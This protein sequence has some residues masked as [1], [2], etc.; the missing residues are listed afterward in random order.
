VVEIEFESKKMFGHSLASIYDATATVGRY[1]V[2][3]GRMARRGRRRWALLLRSG[4]M[5]REPA[6]PSSWRYCDGL[7]SCATPHRRL[8]SRFRGVWVWPG[9][10]SIAALSLNLEIDA[11]CQK[12]TGSLVRLHR[13]RCKEFHPWA[14]SV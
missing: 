11:M 4:A 5:M 7:R 2:L 13:K 6:T 8:S 9:Y 14:R 10:P 3:W 1:R 12:P